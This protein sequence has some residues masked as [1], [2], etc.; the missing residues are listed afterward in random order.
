[1]SATNPNEK[2]AIA[3]NPDGTIKGVGYSPDGTVLP[4]W[5][6]CSKTAH[7]Y[8]HLCT[9]DDN[10]LL[11]EPTDDAINNFE[12][13][14][15]KK[16]NYVKALTTGFY[17]ESTAVPEING[18]YA[19]EYNAQARISNIEL[20]ISKHGK[21]PGGDGSTLSWPDI[22]DQKHVFTSIELFE[23]F[24][25]AVHNYV[26]EVHMAESIDGPLPHPDIVL[27]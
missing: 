10:G 27:D 17:I 3:L 18:R 25:L 21:F 6:E 20:F 5:R 16:D 19:V 7:K 2:F 11:V 4:N 12:A 14:K 15:Q 26:A 8:W 23:K 22:N 9:I 1:M 24:A 13:N